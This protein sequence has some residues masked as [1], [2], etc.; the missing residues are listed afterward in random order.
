MWFIFR[1]ASK[2]SCTNLTLMNISVILLQRYIRPTITP[3]FT[4]GHQSSPCKATNP[5]SKPNCM[6]M[7]LTTE[8][9]AIFLIFW[10]I[11]AKIWLPWQHPL[12]PCNQKCLLWVGRPRKLP[13]ICNHILAIS[14]RNAFICIYSN[15]SPK[16]GCHCNAPLSLVHGSVTSELP[17]GTN[18][19]S[20]P[21]SV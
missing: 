8:V 19:I 6:D 3:Y 10:P 2:F 15:F 13:V 9:M 17:G 14:H 4:S 21:N 16:I 7:S 12:H 11:L 1:Y 18:P 20:K 5:I